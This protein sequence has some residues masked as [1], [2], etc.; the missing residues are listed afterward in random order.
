MHY[1]RQKQSIISES[2]NKAISQHPENSVCIMARYKL[3]SIITEMFEE[4]KQSHFKPRLML[5]KYIKKLITQLKRENVVL[6]LTRKELVMWSIMEILDTDVD[7]EELTTWIKH[8]GTLEEVVLD[9]DDGM[10]ALIRKG[11]AEERIA[12]LKLKHL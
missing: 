10:L 9:E 3:I 6:Y 5:N 2:T 1:I 11:Q 8:P 7:K 4:L 12:K